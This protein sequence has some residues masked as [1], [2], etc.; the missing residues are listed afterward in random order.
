M[1]A[2]VAVLVVGA[3]GLL[4]GCGDGDEASDEEAITEVVD[5]FT[6][7]VGQ[8]DGETACS[9]LSERGQK[10]AGGPEMIE[11]AEVLGSHNVA[12][13]STLGLIP[14]LTVSKVTVTGD[15]ATVAF[16]HPNQSFTMIRDGDGWL[17]DGVP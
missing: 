9:H 1:S 15:T 13:R 3:S 4:V 10:Q 16:E 17:I 14:S 2:A 7:A 5:Q 11:C 6:A 12:K 8:K